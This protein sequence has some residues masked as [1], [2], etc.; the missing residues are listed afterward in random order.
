MYLE[1]SEVKIMQKGD[2]FVNLGTTV[3]IRSEN[4]SKNELLK[5]LVFDVIKVGRLNVNS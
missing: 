5:M 4:M 1:G 2:S 3:H